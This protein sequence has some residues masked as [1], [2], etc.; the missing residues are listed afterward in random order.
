MRFKKKLLPITLAAFLLCGCGKTEEAPLVMVDSEEEVVSY[1]LIQV[2]Y[3]DVILTRKIDCTYSQSNAQEVSFNVT[4]RYVDKVYVE[5]GDVVKKGDLLCELSSSELEAQIEELEY[6]VKKNELKLANYDVEAGL[7]VQD[8]FLYQHYDYT[9][10]SYAD[11]VQATKDSYERLKV[12]T[13]D[14]LEFDREELSRKRK[15]LKESRL[16]AEFD[17]VVYKLK[18]NLEGSTSKADAVIMNIVDSTDCKFE[19]EGTEF[20]HLFKAGQMVDMNIP[21]SSAAGDYVLLPYEMENWTDSMKFVVY[22]G[23]D[24]AVIDVGTRGTISIVEDQ[25]SHV[26]SLPK[27]V[28]HI[29]GDEAFVY[30]LNEDNIRTIKYITIGLFG[31][32]RVEIADGLAEG[33]KVVKK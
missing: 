25:K 14:E 10:Q 20:K 33:E 28:V 26:L 9:S 2:T 16:Y 7:A 24:N 3:D 19:V 1:S 23:P 31:D 13:N 6:K 32:E 5:E 30:I 15:E 29:A 8:V 22:T 12:L 21:F 11:R 27:D 18:K 17:G 4:G